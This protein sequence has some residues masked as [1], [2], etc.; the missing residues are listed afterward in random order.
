MRTID[1]CA[2]AGG[3]G[4]LRSPTFRRSERGYPPERPSRS[5]GRIGLLQAF[6]LRTSQNF[7]PSSTLLK[8][9]I[10]QRGGIFVVV[11][12]LK[13]NCYFGIVS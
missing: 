10:C 11:A 3:G 13:G 1:V 4:R 9:D 8:S 5:G 6:G 7:G 12:S 2:G